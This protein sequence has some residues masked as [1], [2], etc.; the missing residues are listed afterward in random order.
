MEDL[1]IRVSDDGYTLIDEKAKR[2]HV[3]TEWK[4]LAGFENFLVQR[5]T[6]A[7]KEIDR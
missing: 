5:L 1:G 3:A 7:N 2:V 4:D 6:A